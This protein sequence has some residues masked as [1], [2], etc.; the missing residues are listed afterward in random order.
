MFHDKRNISVVSSHTKQMNALER[1]AEDIQ[2]TLTHSISIL[3]LIN[4]CT[5]VYTDETREG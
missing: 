2:M 3:K 4:T 1:L 5:S